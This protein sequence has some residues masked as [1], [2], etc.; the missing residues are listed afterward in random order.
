MSSIALQAAMPGDWLHTLFSPNPRTTESDNPAPP[1][2]AS[3]L[4]IR[5]EEAL[6]EEALHFNEAAL[7]ELYNRYEPKIYA[8][9]YR[10]TG[11]QL[12][13]EE[14]TAQVFLKMLEAIRADKGW[15]SSFASWLYRIAHN[16]VIDHYRARD[17]QRSV[18]IDDAPDLAAEAGDPVRI[19]QLQIDAEQLRLAMCNLTEEQAEVLTLRFLDGHRVRRVAQIM[20]KTEEAVKALQYRA[21]ANLRRNLEI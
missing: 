19:C 9:V 21:I 15:H 1:N 4:E 3:S 14:L 7:S 10:R 8:Y 2:P 5:G 6:W 17:R 20:G 11:E 16:L 12:L 18:A 13:A